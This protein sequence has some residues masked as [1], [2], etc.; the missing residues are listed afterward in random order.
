MAALRRFLA[1]ALTPVAITVLFSEPGRAQEYDAPG[2]PV[3]ERAEPSLE[4]GHDQ[5]EHLD[6]HPIKN[7]ASLHYNKDDHGGTWEAGEHKMPPPF[8]GQ[9]FNF[10]C[11]AWLLGRF[12]WPSIRR[13]TRERH[14]EITRA[15]SEG[16]R[17][18]EEARR[19]LEEYSARLAGLQG[20]IDKLV[21]GIRGEA[22]SEKARIIA[23]AEARAERMQRDAEQQIQAEM[24]QVRASLEREAVEAAVHIAERILG[25]ET[26]DA[27]QKALADRFLHGLQDAAKGRRTTV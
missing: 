18:R 10:L 27:D 13:A 20:E 8:A 22:E 17:L 3:E 9:I 2:T 4:S 1:I 6:S 24:Q 7:V 15:L 5:G 23:E 19:R 26:T 25:E 16:T 11:F 14:D 12:A 21:G